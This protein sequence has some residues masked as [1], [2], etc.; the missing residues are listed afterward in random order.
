[1]P[2]WRLIKL[3]SGIDA[4]AAAGSLLQG[5][6]AHYLVFS[7][8]PLKKGDACLVHAGAGGTGLMVIQMAKRAGA[9]VI[10]TVSTEAKGKLAK[11]AGA[12]V[13]INYVE[14]DFEEETMKATGGKGVQAAYDAVG[15]RRSTRVWRA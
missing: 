1:M 4:G 14:Q 8:Y 9:T 13:V 15:R 7:T 3:P 11:E 10:T 6:T 12:D 5:M 2:A